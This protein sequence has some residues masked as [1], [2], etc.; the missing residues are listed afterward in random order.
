MSARRL[1]HHLSAQDS[2][3]QLALHA[4]NI[5]R[6]QRAYE[7]CLPPELMNVSRVLNLK[8][9]IVVASAPS[10]AVANRLRQLLPSVLMALR[11]SCGE[12]TEVRVKVQAHEAYRNPVRGAPRSVSERAR[13]KLL[14]GRAALAPGS[15]LRAALEKLLER[16]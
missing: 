13:E 10:G 16:S 2:L 4:R 15:A 1:H 3:A 12:V 8:Q 5:E 11:E 9:G 7:K 14:E 6:V